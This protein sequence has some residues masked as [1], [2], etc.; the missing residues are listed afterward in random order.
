M[1]NVSSRESAREKWEWIVERS[2]GSSIR[3]DK[4]ELANHPPD[5]SKLALIL[6]ENEP[7]RS[8]PFQILFPQT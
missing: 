1:G 5:K 3:E 2:E 7:G 4:G 8:S 6:R